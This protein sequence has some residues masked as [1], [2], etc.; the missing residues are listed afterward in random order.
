MGANP[1]A[2]T[3][4]RGGVWEEMI[5]EAR[6]KE[7]YNQCRAPSPEVKREDVLLAMGVGSDHMGVGLAQCRDA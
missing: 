5:E 3:R 7:V 1:K 6:P 4:R 2:K